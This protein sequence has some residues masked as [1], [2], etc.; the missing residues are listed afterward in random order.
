MKLKE[1]QALPKK[2]FA[3]LTLDKRPKETQ[4]GKTVEIAP[5]MF[6]IYSENEGNGQ[7]A[8]CVIDAN[9][10]YMNQIQ[11]IAINDYPWILIT[12]RGF[13]SFPTDILMVSMIATIWTAYSSLI[14]NQKEN[15]APRI[16]EIEA[17]LDEVFRRPGSPLIRK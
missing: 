14:R 12:Q 8:F 7:F 13:P 15:A 16:N 10:T 5:G 6:V 11:I 1:A 17:K 9:G 2:L 4:F 3:S